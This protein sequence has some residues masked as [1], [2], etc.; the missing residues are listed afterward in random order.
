MSALYV[1]IK[2][3]ADA[4]VSQEYGIDRREKYVIGSKVCCHL[5]RKI[6]DDLILGI[7]KLKK[8]KRHVHT[9]Y[10]Q[11]PPPSMCKYIKYMF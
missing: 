1:R 8:N 6:R 2:Q 4:Y 10:T 7:M 9:L 3:F 5:L 11:A